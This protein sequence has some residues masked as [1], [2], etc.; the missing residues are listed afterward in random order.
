MNK[1]RGPKKPMVVWVGSTPITRITDEERRKLHKLMKKRLAIRRKKYPKCAA[2]WWTTSRIPLRTQ[3]STLLSGSK[4][5]PPFRFA[6]AVT[7]SSSGLIKA[8]GRAE[9]ITSFAST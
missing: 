9:T 2:R 5:R 8:I 7:C 1:K 4:T 6:T 3:R